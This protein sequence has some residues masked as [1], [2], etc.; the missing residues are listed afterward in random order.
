MNFMQKIIQLKTFLVLASSLSV[1]F[2]VYKYFKRNN[3]RRNDEDINGKVVVVTGGS[4][5]KLNCFV[6]IIIKQCIKAVIIVK[7]Q[8]EIFLSLI[9]RIVEYELKGEREKLGFDF[10]LS[11]FYVCPALTME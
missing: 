7:T 6:M 3:I 5:G 8:C 4:S 11:S 9:T 2:L 10:S 1:E